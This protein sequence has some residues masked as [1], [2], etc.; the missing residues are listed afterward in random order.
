M[1]EKFALGH[2][3]IDRLDLNSAV[4]TLTRAA[5]A[6]RCSYVVTP[7][8]DHLVMLESNAAFREVYSGALL[9]LADGMPIVWA[10]RLLG[11]PLKER[12]TGADLLPR[13]CESSAKEGLKVFLLGAGPGVAWEAK[14]NLE[15]QYPG[16]RIVD[17]YSPPY[18]FEHNTDENNRIVEKIRDSEADIIFVGLG[19]PKQEL[20]I[21]Q[22]INRFDRGLFLGVGAAIDFC[23]N[24]V[25]RAPRWMQRAGIEWS[26]RLF[27]EPRRLA[28]R[29]AKDTRVLSIILRQFIRDRKDR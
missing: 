26:Y 17:V 28:K 12:V 9:T 20:W 2:A 29:Y 8:S 18:G 14:K 1:S 5:R 4:D 25:S 27:Q 15:S 10:S 13:L 3:R 22:N 23:A 11:K 21:H 19:A 16:L 24:R 7:N 6:E